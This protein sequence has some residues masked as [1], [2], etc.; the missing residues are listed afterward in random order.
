MGTTKNITDSDIARAIGNRAIKHLREMYSYVYVHTYP[1]CRLSLRNHIH[2]DV[3]ALI[4]AM[5]GDGRDQS[6]VA[7]MEADGTDESAGIEPELAQLEGP[8]A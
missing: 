4:R 3:V 5:R 2:N 1:S 7:H 6:F 8:T